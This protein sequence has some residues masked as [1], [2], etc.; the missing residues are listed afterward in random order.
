MG[1]KVT[2]DEVLLK[3]SHKEIELV[4]Y[5]GSSDNPSK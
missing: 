3:I 4:E 2:K 1:R 5:S